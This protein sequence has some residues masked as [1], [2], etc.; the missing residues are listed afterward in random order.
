MTKQ[1]INQALGTFVSMDNIQKNQV[2]MKHENGTAFYS[3]GTFIGAM[4]GG[5]LYLTSDHEHSKTTSK[6]CGQWCGHNLQERRAMLQDGR[7]VLID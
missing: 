2:I 7:A 6:Y 5:K 4:T 1:Q 3:Y